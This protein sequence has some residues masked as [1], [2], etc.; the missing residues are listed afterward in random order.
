MQTVRKDF[1]QQVVHTVQELG[2]VI[3][4]IHDEKELQN[5]FGVDL[6]QMQ[7]VLE[8]VVAALPQQFFNTQNKKMIKEVK[9]VCAREFIFFQV[10]EK[11]S[12]P[13][14]EENLKAFINCFS[15]DMAKRLA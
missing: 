1:L 2:K 3:F 7:T 15:R 10:Q 6:K 8:R 5:V 9:D 13:S 14:Y 12:D 11:W 4:N